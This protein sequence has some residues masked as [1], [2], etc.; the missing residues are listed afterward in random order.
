[1]NALLGGACLHLQLV[2]QLEEDCLP[3]QWL[4]RGSQVAHGA[5]SGHVGHDDPQS[6]TPVR[7]YQPRGFQP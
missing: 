4:L 2:E 1:M 6:Q 5:P 7:W 3:G